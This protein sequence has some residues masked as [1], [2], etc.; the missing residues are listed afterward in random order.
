MS[1]V[2]LVS[3]GKGFYQMIDLL[4]IYP[5]RIEKKWKRENC[6]NGTRTI[7]KSKTEVTVGK[8]LTSFHFGETPFLNIQ[9]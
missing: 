9:R 1:V 7:L 8:T 4:H 6:H 2:K 3:Y 5:R